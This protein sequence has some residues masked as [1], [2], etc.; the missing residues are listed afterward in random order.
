MIKESSNLK[1][2]VK[3]LALPV[4]KS[5]AVQQME[6]VRLLGSFTQQ[7]RIQM[8][9]EKNKAYLYPQV[10]NSNSI[11]FF[12]CIYFLTIIRKEITMCLVEE[13]GWQL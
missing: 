11:F 5:A 10:A 13:S 6:T 4:M 2:H 12:C 9:Q 3:I 1:R 7:S 8:R